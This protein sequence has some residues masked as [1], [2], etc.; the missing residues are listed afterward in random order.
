M[1]YIENYM[2]SSLEERQR[3]L[4]LDE[5]CLERGGNSSDFRGLMAEKFD[6]TIPV[7]KQQ[8]YLCHACN[9]DKCGNSN[10]LYWG[11][12]LENHNDKVRAGKW[13]NPWELLVQRVGE[14]KAHNIAVRAGKIGGKVFAR[15]LKNQ[16]IA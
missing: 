11:T 1:I 8:I 6:T 5:F 3:H 7:K 14:E 12:P 16:D 13:K 10:H 4:K 9:N 2:K 15:N